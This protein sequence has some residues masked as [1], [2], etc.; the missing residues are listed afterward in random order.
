MN[1][2]MLA[3]AMLLT[4]SM[5]WAQST[6]SITNGT[7]STAS[8]QSS[9]SNNVILPSGGNSYIDYGGDYT[10]RSA[11]T[12]Y[13]PGLTASVT[14]TCWGSVSGGV[15]V[16]GVGV[17][18]GATVKDLDC[19]KRLNAAVAW[20][21]GRQDIAFNIMCQEDDFRNAAAMTDKPCKE[22][23]AKPTAEAQ[24]LPTAQIDKQPPTDDPIVR[25]REST[26][27]P[28]GPASPPPSSP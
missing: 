18:G 19:N 11:P 14:E 7:N 20:K 2:Y 13:A 26:P 23:P 5:V 9:V 1:K 25:Y 21:M 27:A 4:S 16:V 6:G 28:A 24:I 17:T 10:V 3:T 12:I 22:V 15:S 8:Q